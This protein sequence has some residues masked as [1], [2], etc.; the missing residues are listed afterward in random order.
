ML[1]SGL[2][3]TVTGCVKYFV[4]LS[5]GKYQRSDNH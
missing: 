1:L 4:S 3:V 2:L 5:Y